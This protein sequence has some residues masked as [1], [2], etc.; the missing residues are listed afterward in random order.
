MRDRYRKCRMC[1]AINKK[2]LI[3]AKRKG[4]RMQ[5]YKYTGIIENESFL[6]DNEVRE[7]ARKNTQNL[8]MKTS[9]FNEH[10]AEDGFFFI[11]NITGNEIEIG[12]I[13]TNPKSFE[14]R[15]KRY[16]DDL[17]LQITDGRFEETTLQTIGNMLSNACR[18]GFINDDD[19]VLEQFEL[20]ELG[21]RRNGNF[22]ENILRGNEKEKL[23]AVAKKYLMQ[24]TFI[25]ELERIY[26]PKKTLMATG[27]PVHYIFEVDNRD[28]RKEAYRTLLSALHENGRLENRRYCY[29]DI[30]ASSEVPPR[31]FDLLY[32]A[33]IGGSVV[34][35]FEM[36]EELEGS[37][38]SSFR[39]NIR[40]VSAVAEKY[41]N[42]VLTIIC[43]PRSCTKFKEALFAEIRNICFYEIREDQVTGDPARTYLK[44]LAKENKIRAD[45]KLLE[46]VEDG[47]CYLSTELNELFSGWYDKKLRSS[48]YPQYKDFCRAEVQEQKAK[49]QGNAYKEL[50]DMIG[51]TEAKKVIKQAV[52]YFKAQKLFREN[53]MKEDHPTMHMVFMGN[54]GTAKTTTARLFADIM[55]ENG[56]LSKG[57]LVE[58]GRADLVGQYVGQTAPKVKSCI[59]R[60]IGGC[61]FIDEAYS[62]VD[63]RDGLYGDEAINTLVQEMENHRDDLVIIFAGYPNKMQKFLDKNPGLRSRIAFNVNFADYNPSELSEIAEHIAKEKGLS[64]TPGAKEKLSAAFSEAIHDKD[65]G[66]GRYVRN[67]IE[68]ARMAQASRLVRL[69]FEKVTRDVLSTI[70]EEDIEIPEKVCTAVKHPIGFCA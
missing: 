33:N 12:A 27:H 42:K 9:D 55:R 22:G 45:K 68:K 70:M 1:C 7:R 41:R 16:L 30:T 26:T 5:F 36:K 49:P 59:K 47:S 23:Y 44:N 56:L 6:A 13:I 64:F 51:L 24:E 28:M 19:E 25:P 18:A 17:Q 54:P 40:I 29:T 11:R 48:V 3:K 50:D 35:R 20:D 31:I 67:V 32:K 62:L 63:D 38:A 8:S 66:N 34:I 10:N 4:N 65:F 52:D 60:A 39:E 61:L 46:L 57:H 15:L 21:Y 37:Y 69:P 2:K 53:G 58:V 14:K 43:F